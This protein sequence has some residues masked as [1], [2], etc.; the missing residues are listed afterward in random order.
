MRSLTLSDTPDILISTPSKCLALLQAKVSDTRGRSHGAIA[1]F[2]VLATAHQHALH[3]DLGYP[4]LGR[5]EQPLKIGR[6]AV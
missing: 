4:A 1:Q 6:V 2:A 5:I 3:A